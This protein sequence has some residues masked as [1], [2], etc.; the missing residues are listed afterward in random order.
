VL[1]QDRLAIIDTAVDDVKIAQQLLGE[2]NVLL[3]EAYDRLH[4]AFAETD[5]TR[6]RHATSSLYEAN[7][8]TGQVRVSVV[9]VLECLS[10]FRAED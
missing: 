4:T 7:S 3:S 2:A 10:R 6:R 5:S 8:A 1:P 9:Q